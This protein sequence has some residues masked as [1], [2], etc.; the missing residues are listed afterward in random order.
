MRT[1]M[2][3][4]FTELVDDSVIPGTPD[5]NV[6]PEK[7]DG[8]LLMRLRLRGFSIFP[9]GGVRFPDDLELCNALEEVS[10]VLMRN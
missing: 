7:L 6:A 1:S 8:A 9:A 2:M 4:S 3:V 5:L 10:G